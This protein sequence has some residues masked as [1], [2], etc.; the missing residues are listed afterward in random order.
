MKNKTT[1]Q[2]I[3][4]G[5]FTLQR[6]SSPQQKHLDNLKSWQ[7]FYSDRCNTGK[8]I[9][10]QDWKNNNQLKTVDETVSRKVGFFTWNFYNGGKIFSQNS[11]LDVEKILNSKSVKIDTSKDNEDKLSLLKVNFEIEKIINSQRNYRSNKR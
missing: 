1:K 2:L 6:E 8:K 9:E 10:I 4:E 7:A 5:S 11:Y 3:N